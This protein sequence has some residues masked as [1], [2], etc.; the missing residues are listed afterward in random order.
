MCRY[1]DKS[2]DWEV[3]WKE[4]YR[5]AEGPLLQQIRAQRQAMIPIARKLRVVRINPIA[6]DWSCNFK[7]NKYQV[8]IEIY[9]PKDLTELKQENVQTIMCVKWF[10]ETYNKPDLRWPANGDRSRWRLV[11][12][13][14]RKEFNPIH[15]LPKFNSVMD[16]R[17]KCCK[18]KGGFAKGLKLEVS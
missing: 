17:K 7:L 6:C 16:I 15:S 3:K 5:L 11:D 4:A 10:S 2:K 1:G 9:I 12:P 8:Q 18:F 14:L 13:A